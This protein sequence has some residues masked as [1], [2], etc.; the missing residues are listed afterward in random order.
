MKYTAEGI[1]QH[2]QL[3][4][5]P[6][7]GYFKEV[8]RSRNG[9]EFHDETQGIIGFRNYLT[10]IYFLLTGDSFSAFHRINQD[11]SWHFY[12]GAPVTI[13]V[14]NP[15]GQLTQFKL[16]NDLNSDTEFQ[17]TIPANHWFAA[18]VDTS[19]S[20]AFVGCNVAPGFEFVDFELT[21]RKQLSSEYP[22]HASLIREL[23]R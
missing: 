15:E 3:A 20:F 13:F 16:S 2:F 17:V 4:P 19:E 12:L 22:Q 23:T 7:G 1:I 9:S 8:F 10:G 18:K 21:D 11:E 14:I 5:H 6:E